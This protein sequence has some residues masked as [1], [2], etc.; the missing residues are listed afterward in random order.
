MRE[1]IIKALGWEEESVV[2]KVMSK[3]IDFLLPYQ[4]KL[5]TFEYMILNLD[6]FDDYFGDY[7][8]ISNEVEIARNDELVVYKNIYGVRW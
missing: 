5:L 2:E 8:G 1:F 4:E 7:L 3:I 6:N